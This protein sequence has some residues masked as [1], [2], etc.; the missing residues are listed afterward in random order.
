[1]GLSNVILIPIMFFILTACG[2]GPSSD[3]KV[4]NIAP[5]E[6]TSILDNQIV[7][8]SALDDGP[9]PAGIARIFIVNLENPS[10]SSLCTGFL[11]NGN[12]VVTNHHC[13]SQMQECESTYVSVFNGD[14]TENAKC[15]RIIAA[16]DDGKH[17][18]ERSVDVTIFELDRKIEKSRPFS[19]AASMP[20]L[21][22]TLSV[23]VMDHYDLY[24]ARLTELAC[25][26]QSKI[27]SIELG[28][29]AAISGNSGSPVLDA[30]GD[31]LGV[32]WGSTTDLSVN[33]ATD[34]EE[35]RSRDDLSYATEVDYF[36]IYIP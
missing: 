33:S 27:D 6:I 16:L 8:C 31:V 12:R 17:P 22:S 19:L 18:E 29:C 20:L 34:L 26:F 32:L 9:C 23:W 25:S 13:F 15:S 28:N 3:K 36:K 4:V 10:K 24:T 30:S 2:G 11:V 1:M 5:E 14:I 7:D 21:H 35:R